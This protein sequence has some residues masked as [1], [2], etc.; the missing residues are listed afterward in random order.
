MEF[1][2]KTNNQR[3]QVHEASLFTEFAKTNYQRDHA[4]EYLIIFNITDPNNRI[5]DKTRIEPTS[6]FVPKKCMN[7]GYNMYLTG[8]LDF[9]DDYAANE[10]RG[11]FNYRLTGK[12]S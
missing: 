1:S 12:I 9:D 8:K 3:F 2:W 4:K 10:F 11:Y 5:F 7:D 6:I